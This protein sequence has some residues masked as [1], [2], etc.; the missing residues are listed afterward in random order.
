MATTPHWSPLR[1]L[2]APCLTLR[3]SCQF[4]LIPRS[5]DGRLHTKVRPAADPT[6]GG[7]DFYEWVEETDDAITAAHEAVS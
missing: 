3:L 6:F 2:P 5:A 4:V 1:C 7:L